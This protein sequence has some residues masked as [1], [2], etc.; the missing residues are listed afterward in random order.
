MKL[1]SDQ[2]IFIFTKNK[3]INQNTTMR[4]VYQE[5][6]DEDGFPAEID[7]FDFDPNIGDEGFSGANANCAGSDC[8][9]ILENGYSVG[10][11]ILKGPTC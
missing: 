4:D 6:C 3:L 11:F 9:S 2:A 8:L 1:S 7:C 10:T 5:D